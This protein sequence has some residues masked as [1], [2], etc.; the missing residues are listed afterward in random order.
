MK[1]EPVSLPGKFSASIG[2]IG[3]GEEIEFC[4]KL[5]SANMGAESTDTT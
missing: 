1:T 3:E 2:T 4:D 5:T